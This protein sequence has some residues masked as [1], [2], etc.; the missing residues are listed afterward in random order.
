MTATAGITSNC[1]LEKQIP[2][3]KEEEFE[4]GLTE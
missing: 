3:Q 4:F 2:I 1:V